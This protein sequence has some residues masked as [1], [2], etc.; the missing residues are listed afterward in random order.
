MTR[1]SSERL[2]AREAELAADEDFTAWLS[3]RRGEHPHAAE[4][5]ARADGLRARDAGN[6][7]A[8]SHYGHRAD[9]LWTA[10][11]AA[12]AVARTIRGREVA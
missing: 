6:D 5:D 1:G 3:D 12:V 7:D 4:V 8:T 2:A 10:R 9:R 11:E